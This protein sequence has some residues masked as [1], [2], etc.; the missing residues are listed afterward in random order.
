[1]AIDNALRSVCGFGLEAFCTERTGEAALRHG[2]HAIAPEVLQAA[3]DVP[4]SLS[5]HLDD[6][7]C[8]RYLGY[9]LGHYAKNHLGEELEI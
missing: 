9:F 8:N 1:M 3:L 6:Y 7:S 2:L 4:R 5:L